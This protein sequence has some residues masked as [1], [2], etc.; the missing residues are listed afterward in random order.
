MHAVEPDF[1]STTWTCALGKD[2]DSYYERARDE[3]GVALYAGRACP[4][5][6]AGAGTAALGTVVL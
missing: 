3:Y 1:L 5:V 6:D 2:F 4:T